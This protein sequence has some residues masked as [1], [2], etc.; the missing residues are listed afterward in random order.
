MPTNTNAWITREYPVNAQRRQAAV[1][2]ALWPQERAELGD[3]IKFLKSK[4]APATATAE[5]EKWLEGKTKNP[6]GKAPPASG[7]PAAP[8]APA[9]APAEERDRRRARLGLPAAGNPVRKVGNS[10]VLGSMT[11]EQ[12]MARRPHLPHHRGGAR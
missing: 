4:G 1:D 10:L 9:D 7:A 12:A 3:L 8:A 11:R 2:D 5:L 6:G